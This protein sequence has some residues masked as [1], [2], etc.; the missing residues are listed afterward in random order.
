VMGCEK[1]MDLPWEYTNDE[2]L[3]EIVTRTRPEQFKDTIWAT[4]EKWDTS[5]VAVGFLIWDKGKGLLAR[6]RCSVSQ[7]YFDC[8]PNGLDGWK[9]T[10]CTNED[11]QDVLYFLIPVTNPGNDPGGGN[12]DHMSVP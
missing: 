12:S 3:R 7:E 6:T 2:M 10:S 9:Y 5:K 4:L 8:I 1:L 11:L